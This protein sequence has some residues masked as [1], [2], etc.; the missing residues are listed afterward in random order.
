MKE[1]KEA[2]PTIPIPSIKNE[3]AS[4]SDIRDYGIGQKKKRK[5]PVKKKAAATRNRRSASQNTD[6][7]GEDDY[8]LRLSNFLTLLDAQNQGQF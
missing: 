1:P 7:T 8:L 4:G 2:C 3:T 5:K 6:D